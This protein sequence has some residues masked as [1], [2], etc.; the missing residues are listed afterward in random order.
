M[1]RKRVSEGVSALRDAQAEGCSG[2]EEECGRLGDCAKRSESVAIAVDLQ[3][4][5][6]SWK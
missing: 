2:G 3:P 6:H 1:W 4:Y 5:E